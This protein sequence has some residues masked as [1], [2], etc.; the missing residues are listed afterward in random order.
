[1]EEQEIE[2]DFKRATFATSFLNRSHRYKK[3][4]FSYWWVVL[5][6]IVLCTGIQLFLLW[7]ALPSFTSTGRMIVNVKLSIPNANLY[8]EELNNFFG[9]QEELMRS[10]SV[11]NRANLRL[12]AA[13][14]QFLMHPVQIKVTLSP[15]TSIFNL[16]AS[17]GNPRSTQAYLETTMEEYVK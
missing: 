2:T 5:S 12:Q 14:P 13:D 17:G 10:D 6:A 7:H 1:M 3:L 4:L 15:K 16:S 9:T 11:R 8:S